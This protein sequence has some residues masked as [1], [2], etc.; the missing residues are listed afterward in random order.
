LLGKGTIVAGYRIDGVLGEGGMSVVYRA[1]QLSLNRVVAL[2]LLSAELSEDPGFRARFEREGQLQAALDDQHIVA[3][4]ETGESEYGRF[5]AMRLVQGPTLKDLILGKELDTRRSLRLLAQ[6]AQ[7]LDTAHAAGL[8]HR[9]VKP[10]NILI[11]KGDHV[12]LADFGLTKALDDTARLTGTGQFLGTIDY[13]APEQ[14]QGEAATAASDCY[15]LTAVLYECLTGQVPFV[16]TSEA[17]VMYAHLTEP[18]PRAS[19]VRPDLPSAIDEVLASGL[20]KDPTARP[21][22]ATELLR[23]ATRA[24]GSEPAPAP[25]GTQETRLRP[26]VG[27][28]PSRGTEKVPIAGAT[29]GPAAAA[30]LASGGAATAASSFAGAQGA[31]AAEPTRP[32]AGAA[33]P[34]PSAA[35]GYAAPRAA[36]RPRARI[37]PVGWIAAV[38]ALAA[39]A[40]GFLVGHTGS[41]SSGRFTNTATVGDVQLRYPSGWQ[42]NPSLP[43][44]PGM[45][46]TTPLA[47]AR[48]PAVGGL[49]AGELADASGPTLLASGFR[50]RVAGGV[51]QGEQVQLGGLQAYRYQNLH[52]DGLSGTVTVYAVP[53]SAGVATVACWSSSGAASAFPTECGQVAATLRLVGATPYPITPSA[54]YSRLLSSTFAQLRASAATRTAELRAASTAAGQAAAATALSAAYANAA[55]RLSAATVSPQVRDA[56]DAIVAALREIAAGYSQAAAAARSGSA[57]GYANASHMIEAGSVALGNALRSLAGL[58]YTTGG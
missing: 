22:S 39:I 49:Q 12:Y 11:D 24:L 50:S 34:S 54:E 52:V 2:K 28:A 31:T 45:T 20:A 47:L 17:A 44:V 23:A 4:Y 56:Q 43:S 14:I 18:P 46:F 48:T 29:A 5:L 32:S 55:T 33:G 40:I 1:T 3:V 27:G 10:Q 58:G 37:G 41:S 19:D 38:L 6:V 7:A 51:P 26:S 36:E 21:S 15:A 42:L 9:D 16:R 13:V 57:A 53:T 25:A 30:T 8:I 35:D